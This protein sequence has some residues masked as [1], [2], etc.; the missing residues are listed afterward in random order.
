M[1]RRS[2]TAEA[3]RRNRSAGRSGSGKS[4][5]PIVMLSAGVIASILATVG[6]IWWVANKLTDDSAPGTDSIVA[7]SEAV[8]PEA[9]SGAAGTE[10]NQSSIDTSPSA[11]QDSPTQSENSNPPTQSGF[12]Q[13]P[14]NPVPPSN[15]RPTFKPPSN[16][17]PN[18]NSPPVTV[19]RNSANA[20]RYRLNP[21]DTH[22]YSFE[23]DVEVEGQTLSFPGNVTFTVAKGRAAG[24][25][26]VQAG[27]GT[28]FVVSSDGYLVTCHHVIEDATSI[29]VLLSGTTYQGTVVAIDED[30]DLAVVKIEA[31]NL[32]FV[33][34]ANSD[35]VQLAED[36]RAIGYPLT[37]M[38]GQG[39]KVTRGTISGINED[40]EARRFQIDASI[41]P[42]NSGGPLFNGA[43]HVI[44]VNSAKLIS[45]SSISSVG[46]SVPVNYAKQIL[47]Q[48]RLRF[49]SRNGGATLAGPAL[50]Q[51]VKSSVALLKVESRR[52][53]NQQY[54]LNYSGSYTDPLAS[55]GSSRGPAGMRFGPGGFGPPGFS[56]SSRTSSRGKVVLDD[57][58][59]VDDFEDTNQLPFS[60]GSMAMLMVHQFDPD[61]AQS[62]TH[63]NR[64]VLTKAKKRDNSPFGIP[65]PRFGGPFGRQQ[66]EEP[67]EILTGGIETHRYRIIETNDREIKIAKHYE[68][69]TLDDP[70][71]PLTRIKG[72]GTIVFDRQHSMPKSMSFKQTYESNSD[73][74]SMTI[75]IAISYQM[76]DPS[77][78]KKQQ[79]QIAQ[80][81]ADK[82]AEQEERA[83]KEAAM[84][85]DQRLDFY[86]AEIKAKR[87][88]AVFA[89]LATMEVVESKR[90]EVC[91]LLKPC[92]Q[93]RRPDG[94]E[95]AALGQWATPEIISIMILKLETMETHDWSTGRSLVTALGKTK[96]ERAIKPMVMRLTARSHPWHDS[97]LKALPNFGA[98][99]EDEVIAFLKVSPT[100]EAVKA[101]GIVGTTKSLSILKELANSKDFWI[102]K[103]AKEA[104]T[105]VALRSN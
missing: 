29:E 5:M 61:G 52:R 7:Q 95:I 81:A 102:K 72:T 30:Q 101:L 46:F 77:I 90:A 43:G 36:V 47:Q 92:L 86:I 12:G 26:E 44:A 56:S 39:L 83:A 76:Q 82:K 70:I 58:G 24:A 105:K 45:G 54:V 22:D 31:K 94:N 41:N 15:P 48:N 2:K 89:K 8:D 96:D 66:Q 55:S 73:G 85:D 18:P 78:R 98:K 97:V 42:G 51:K 71:H 53:V 6:A 21:G 28:G 99:A 103:A 11:N 79:E 87:G 100:D 93:A 69:K 104:I 88:K 37:E 13:N 3:A 74:E 19:A 64:F 49:E 25:D 80:A 38:L 34:L 59:Q 57:F 23:M 68:L 40:P 84:S 33:S 4:A 91:D 17:N 62:W 20:I 50:V 1:P 14:S 35:Q 65:G 60:T 27:T 16:P 63:E 67:D 9:D 75:P 32:P 10:N